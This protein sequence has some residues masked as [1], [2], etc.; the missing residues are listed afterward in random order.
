M[1]SYSLAVCLA[2]NGSTADNGS[3]A[4]TADNGSVAAQ[5]SFVNI[6][7]LTRL[8]STLR[9]SYDLIFHRIFVK[10]GRNVNFEVY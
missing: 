3:V 1:N 2:D 7:P 6:Y 5:W 8:F 4:D 10:L 9:G